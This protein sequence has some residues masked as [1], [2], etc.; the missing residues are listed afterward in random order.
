MFLLNRLISRCFYR[1][2]L[3]VRQPAVNCIVISIGSK[4][5]KTII[6]IKTGEFHSYFVV[7][8]LLASGIDLSTQNIGHTPYKWNMLTVHIVLIIVSLH[9]TKTKMF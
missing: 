9:E 7:V 1:T 6:R 3:D 2:A 4:T 5:M 8:N